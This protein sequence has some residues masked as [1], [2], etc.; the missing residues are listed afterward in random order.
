MKNEIIIKNN[1]GILTVSSL[2]VAKD[3]EKK[4]QSCDKRHR[5]SH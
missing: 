1:E 5:K 4:S 2:Q 3:F